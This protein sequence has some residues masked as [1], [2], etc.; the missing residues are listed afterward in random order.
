MVET[1][2]ARRTRS[3]ARALVS[4]AES[5][6]FRVLTLNRLSLRNLMWF[7]WAVSTSNLKHKYIHLNVHPNANENL[8]CGI[9]NP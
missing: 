5:S 6:A 3:P 7:G 8:G 1:A 4:F 9:A 2:V